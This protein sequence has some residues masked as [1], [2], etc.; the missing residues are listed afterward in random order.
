M[1][2]VA[3]LLGARFASPKAI[4]HTIRRTGFPAARRLSLQA[5]DPGAHSND[6]KIQQE[7]T[8]DVMAASRVPLGAGSASGLDGG[9]GIQR[10]GDHSL[11]RFDCS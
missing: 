6:P 2:T 1:V 8:P 7:F 3:I 10:R 11:L 9:T 5:R 4:G